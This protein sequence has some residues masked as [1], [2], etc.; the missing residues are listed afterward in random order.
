MPSKR[1][2]LRQAPAAPPGPTPEIARSYNETPYRCQAHPYTHP[3]RL[4]V[5]ATLAG[6]RPAPIDHCRVLE[7]GCNEGS[8][9]LAMA[10]ALPGSE[11]VGI[12]L[13]AEPIARGNAVIRDLGLANA[14][15]AAADLCAL[16]RRYGTFD[17]IIAH[18]VYSWVPATVREGL[19]TLCRE[20]LTPQGVAYISYN[21]MPGGHLRLMLREMLQFH[22][23]SLATPGERAAEART[24]ANFLSTG[25]QNFGRD[26]AYIEI[27]QNEQ[28]LIARRHAED[29]IHDELGP[30]NEPFYFG[31]FMA[32]AAHHELQYLAEAED[33]Q[34]NPQLFGDEIAQQLHEIG[35]QSLVA[36]EQYIDF[37]SCRRFR[38][39]LLVRDTV[40]LQRQFEPNVVTSLHFSTQAKR[41]GEPNADG[42]Q[43]FASEVRGSV[44]TAD[45]LL[46]RAMDTLSAAAP[47][48]LS[49][50]EL[51]NAIAPPSAGNEHGGRFKA[52][53]S[54]AQLLYQGHFSGLIETSTRPRTVIRRPAE[55]PIASGFARYQALR[56]DEVTTLWH[57]NRTMAPFERALFLLLDGEH[58]RQ[59]LAAAL[60]PEFGEGEPP[61]AERV[62]DAIRRFGLTGALEQ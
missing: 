57:E 11:F 54:L 13:A 27:L 18:G 29:L 40:P 62:E 32:R 39:S 47:T 5:M 33:Y 53:R 14:H 58:D 36:A 10:Y 8:N 4:A 43:L 37:L 45:A 16:D 9:L 59:A 21:T 46:I 24:F 19:L 1:G 28:R 20:R 34:M 12:D 60:T 51:L 22:T 56:N 52:S 26:K 38:R 3:D 17:Y 48:T 6:M 41:D 2:A 23:S 49:F 7:V 30:V 55:R 50:A 15:L 31:Q 61:L 44:L 42:Y 25:A 35:A